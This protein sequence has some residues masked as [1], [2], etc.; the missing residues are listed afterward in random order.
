MDLLD[1]LFDTY[2]VN[3]I[4]G[5]SALQAHTDHRLTESTDRLATLE[6]RYERLHVVTVALWSLLKEHTG[7]TDGDLKKFVTQVEE[8]DTRAHGAPGTM[9][10]E[11]CGRIIKQSATR[12]IYCGS[13]VSKGNAFQGT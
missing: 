9:K 6:L 12:C 2:A 1:L 10:C 8:S 7:L 4:S 3:K 5:V 13:A 11:K